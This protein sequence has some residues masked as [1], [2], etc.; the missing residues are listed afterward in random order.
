MQAVQAVRGRQR[1]PGVVGGAAS[2]RGAARGGGRDAG[3]RSR[4][5]A[6]WFCPPAGGLACKTGSGM[7]CLMLCFQV[8]TDYEACSVFKIKKD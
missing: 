7:P 6:P 1:L 3:G 8:Q 5:A 4:E 2:Y